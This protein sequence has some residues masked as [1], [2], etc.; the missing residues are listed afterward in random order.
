MLYVVATCGPLL[1]SSYRHIRRYGV[2]NLVAVCAL[3]WLNQSGLISLWCVWAAVTSVA[4][5]VH[6]RTVHRT[7]VA[8]GEA[9]LTREE[10]PA[11]EVG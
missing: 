7:P 8:G 2:L 4:I 9:P 5:A 1:F 11:G 6:L 10:A 3:A